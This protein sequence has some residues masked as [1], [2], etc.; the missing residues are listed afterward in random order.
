MREYRQKRF[1]YL[2]DDEKKT[3]WI[4]RGH[5][6][7]CRR[8]RLPDHV[9][10]NGVRYTVE[11]VE[12]SSFNSPRTLH[13]LVIPDSY[14][15]VDED[16]LGFF[17]NLRSVHVGK[18]V[19]WLS[20]WHFRCCPKLRS[21]T[22]DKENPHMDIRDGIVFSKD[23]KLIFT[24]IA[25]HQRLVIPEGVEEIADVAFWCNDK[26]ESV[27]FPST[28]RKIGDNSFSNCSRL[29]RIVLPEGFETC[30]CQCF[31]ENEGLDV[32]DFPSTL[33]DMGYGGTFARCP[34]LKSLTLWMPSVYDDI[35]ADDLED[36]PVVTCRLYVPA[37]LVEGYRRHPVWG[38]FRDILPII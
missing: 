13:H 18:R 36:V 5:I 10:V 26:L 16:C 7:R 38:K 23:G 9:M 21:Y 14:S 15:Y 12:I 11:S 27:S 20:A 22:I 34:N 19:G 4:K 17:R 31:G 33:A 3:A 24:Q 2:L 6:G 28:L 29:R 32:I 35:R 8:Y 1:V 37:D 25:K 30:V